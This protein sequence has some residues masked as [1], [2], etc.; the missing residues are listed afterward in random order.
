MITS[1]LRSAR[2]RRRIGWLWVVLTIG[3]VLNGL[4]LRARLQS[5]A[6]V[7]PAPWRGLEPIVDDVDLG[8]DPDHVFLTAPGVVL[9]DETR[10]AASAYANANDLDVVD[11]VPGDL[12]IERAYEVVRL[13][14]PATYRTNPLT[15][16]RGPQQATLV[17]R[18]VLARAGISAEAALDPVAYLHVTAELKRFAAR[19]TDLAVAPSLHAAPEKLSRRRAHLSA[20]YSKAMPAFVATPA[21][22]YATLVAGVVVAPVWGTAALAAFVAQ[23]YF[24]FAGTPVHPN[25][26][27]PVGAVDRPVRG[28][29]RALRSARGTWQPPSSSTT[30]GASTAIGETTETDEQKALVYDDLLADGIERFFEPRRATCPL[31]ESTELSER[32]AVGDLLQFKPGEFHLDECGGCGHVFQN[33]RLSIEGLDFYYRDFYDGMGGEQLE[34]VFSSDDTSYRGRADLVARHAPTTPKRW[35]DVGGG[36]G[37]FCLVAAGVLPD[38]TFDGLDLGGGIVDAERRRW[39]DRSF[40]GMFPDLAP[41]LQGAYD[42]VSMHHYLEHT[43][44]PAAELDAADTVLESGGHLLIEVPD[45]ECRY[46]RTLGWMWGPWFQPQH[47]HFVSVANLTS[48]LAERGFSV[49][50]V[51]RGPAHQPVDLAFALMLFTNRIAGPPS[52]PWTGPA[53]PLARLRR[54]LCFTALAPVMVGALFLDRAIAPIVRRRG[55]ANTYRLLA[56]KD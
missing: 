25:D 38:T 55:Y 14:D 24:A 2:P 11:L 29:V 43:R 28:L 19:T 44:E 22:Q 40:V 39:I 18:E 13:I 6:T 34:F 33:P 21:V 31:C 50:E 35:L 12:D 51:E 1:L 8:V 27:T 41:D 7:P 36:H 30:V 26:L 20:L 5:L 9:D 3:T 54:A 53:S 46:G 48:L 4:R 17:H 45:P 56:R 10:R 16:G 47:Q 15:I 23:P 49:V 32:I 42:V 52:K 37:H